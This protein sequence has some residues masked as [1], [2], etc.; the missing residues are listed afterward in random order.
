M[1]KFKIRLKRFLSL[2]LSVALITL[3]HGQQITPSLISGGSL[4]THEG[5]VGETFTTQISNGQN[6]ITQGFHQGMIITSNIDEAHVDLEI[7]VFPNPFTSILNIKS[8]AN[9]DARLTFINANGQVVHHDSFD[10]SD[11][12]IDLTSFPAGN[13]HLIFWQD[14]SK[15][16][17]ASFL[18][19]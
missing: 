16:H 3:M 9:I 4:V 14:N 19:F 11:K 8:K 15:I 17:Q 12:S 10:G 7:N 6:L 13:Y 18:K 2:C 5:S 1:K